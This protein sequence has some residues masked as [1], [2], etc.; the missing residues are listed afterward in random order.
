M[1]VVLTRE[2]E[3]LARRLAREAV[4]RRR[5][6]PCWSRRARAKVDE[7]GDSEEPDVQPRQRRGEISRGGRPGLHKGG[8]SQQGQVESAAEQAIAAGADEVKLPVSG[9]RRRHA[10]ITAARLRDRGQIIV[11]ARGIRP[12]GRALMGP[13][14]GTEHHVWSDIQSAITTNM[15]FRIWDKTRLMGGH[16]GASGWADSASQPQSI[17]DWR[18]RKGGSRTVAT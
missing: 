9:E 6:R 1:W 11:A 2:E 3:H 17:S 18:P 15:I 13:N 5:R 12:R 7:G 16:N 4:R 10:G 8:A 14:H